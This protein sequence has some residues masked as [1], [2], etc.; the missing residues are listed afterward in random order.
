M[1]RLLWNPYQ[2]A[3]KLV[4]EYLHGVYGKAFKPMRAYYDLMHAQV[5]APDRHLHVFD[6]VTEEM[7]PESVVS[8]MEELHDTGT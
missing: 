7:W 5:S 3:N 8:Q 6:K 1:A 4:N 2:D